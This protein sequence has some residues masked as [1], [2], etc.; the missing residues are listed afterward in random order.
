MKRVSWFVSFSALFLS[1]GIGWSQPYTFATLAGNAGYGSADGIGSE[2]RFRVPQQLVVDPAGNIY[3]PD[4]GNDTIRKL[5]PLGTNWSVTTIAGQP[6]ILGCDNGVGP[7]THFNNP[8]GLVMDNSGNLYVLDAGCNGIMMIRQL[9]FSGTNWQTFPFVTLPS[10][11]QSL[12]IDAQN[13]IY[14]GD[15]NNYTVCKI[16]PAGALS[17]IAGLAGAYGSADGTNGNAR[18]KDPEGLVADSAGNIYVADTYNYSIRKITPVGTDYV[19]TTIAGS[20]TNFGERDGTNNA[21]AF[22]IPNCITVDTAGNLYVGD[23]NY[24]STIRKVQAQGTNWVVTTIAGLA[25]STGS[26]DGTNS[27]AR[28]ASLN[29][30]IPDGNG[31]IFVSDSS[32]IRSIKPSGTNWITRTMAGLA[33]GPGS[34]DGAGIAA[35]LKY[36]YGVAVDQE[37]NVYVAD[38]GN[39]IIRKITPA[40]PAWIV[41][42]IAGQAGVSDSIDGTNGGA[43]F[44]E[45]AAIAVASSGNIFIADAASSVLREMTASGTNWL[46]TTVAGEPWYW[47]GADGTNASARFYNPCGIAVDPNETLYVADSTNQTIRKVTHTGTNWVVTTMAGLAGTSG[48]SDGTNSSARFKNPR[49]IASSRSGNIYVSDTMNHMIRKL[50]QSGTNWIVTTIAGLAGSSGTADGT[51]SNARFTQPYGVA[52]D[53]AENLFVS[54]SANETVRKL[55]LVGTN[56]VV[57]T[58]AGL[59][60]VYG[61]ADG[62]GTDARFLLPAGIAVDSAGGLFMTDANNHTIRLGW[63]PP[64]LHISVSEPEAILSWPASTFGYGLQTRASLTDVGSW[65][66]VA[67]TVGLDGPRFC[68]TNRIS[69]TNALFRL[70]PQ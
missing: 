69:S 24:N 54:D 56:W 28:F 17:T 55:T 10:R 62:T 47:G 18:F 25:G 60:R 68:V 35:R 48:S 12:A 44:S 46:V 21:A 16:T 67:A 5:F 15:L 51:N 34:S 20:A 26:T 23:Y 45:P 19:V 8:R 49:G 14:L 36:P 6:G 41:T 50:T 53:S 57:T 43:L 9:V 38:S 58:V 7:G 32:L 37:D 59:A 63:S 27:D 64:Q 1:F 3:A 65:A 40:M 70:G 13:N 31:G 42:T 11:Y 22:Q 39:S 52:V 33:G 30:I 29:G 66:G 61:S 2:A 4:E